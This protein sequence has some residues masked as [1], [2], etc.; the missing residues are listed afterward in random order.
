[1]NNAN[2]PSINKVKVFIS[3][4]WKDKTKAEKLTRYLERFQSIDVWM[5]SRNLD[6]GDV[7]SKEIENALKQMDFVLLVW[8]PDAKGRDEG[9]ESVDKKRRNWVFDEI[10]ICKENRI[11]IIPCIF[12]HNQGEAE[13]PFDG[14]WK[15]LVTKDILHIDFHDFNAGFAQLINCLLKKVKEKNKLEESEADP[16][17]EMINRLQEILH[18]QRNYRKRNPNELSDDDKEWT[19]WAINDIEQ[20][21]LQSG[22]TKA[23]QW[24]L[25]LARQS[26]ANDPAVAILIQRLE[27]LLGNVPSPPDAASMSQPFSQ[28]Q[29]QPAE[30]MNHP[31]R[32]SDDLTCRISQVVPPETA[33]MCLAAVQTYLDSAPFA[34]NALSSYI[35]STGSPAGFQVVTYLNNYLVNPNDLIPDHLGRYGKIDDAWLI[36][37]TAFQLIASGLLPAQVIPLDWKTIIAADPVVRAIMPPQAL[38][39]LTTVMQ[40]MLQSIVAEVST[41]Q[42]W[43]TPQGQGYTATM[44]DIPSNGGSWEDQMNSVLFK[45]GLFV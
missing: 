8:S 26:Q 2:N 45:Y 31:N 41:Y 6:P 1:M 40:Q 39:A 22:D 23:G 16:I 30:Q 21:V 33:N 24:C 11:P 20:H 25:E 28:D 13:P 35:G 29:S 14:K 43:L 19:S 36:L 37:N 15:N 44:P 7:L 4:S 10:K 34:L 9:G 3:H 18:H 32:F 42:P 38:A 5:D 17:M 12:S 27:Q